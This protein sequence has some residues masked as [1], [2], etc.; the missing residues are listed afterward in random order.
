MTEALEEVALRGLEQD[1]P[2]VGGGVVLVAHPCAE[3]RTTGRI[4]VAA[5]EHRVDPAG[6]PRDGGVG[7]GNVDERSLAGGPR[8]VDR[9][10]HG[11]RGVQRP[12]LSADVEITAGSQETRPSVSSGRAQPGASCGS[13][14]GSAGPDRTVCPKPDTAQNTT[15]G[16]TADSSS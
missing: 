15:A 3:T 5:V 11:E 13:H 12:R 6:V 16:L 14:T 7:L 10:D 8:P 1:V 9:G 2:V 4:N